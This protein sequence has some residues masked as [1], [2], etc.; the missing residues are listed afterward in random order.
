MNYCRFSLAWML[1]GTTLLAGFM[2]AH[3]QQPS[4]GR[5]RKIEF[6]DPRGSVVTSNLNQIA[7]EKTTF[8]NPEDD[9]K[10]SFDV[11]SPG[12]SL[13]GIGVPQMQRAPS[14][15]VNSKRLKELLE[16]RQEWLFLE[17][18]DYQAGWTAE[19]IFGIPE[20]GPNGEVKEKKSPLERY[21]ERLER[22][23]TA[24]TN[25]TRNEGL[26]G[27]GFG[28]GKKHDGSSK[29]SIGAENE[30]AAIPEIDNP[31]KQ[32]LRGNTGNP[33]FPEKT[34]PTGV[35]DVFGQDGQWKLESPEALRAQ[36]ARLDEF[37]RILDSRTLP[38]LSSS[39]PIS[40]IAPFDPLKTS[41][42]TTPA[43]GLPRTP[44]PVVTFA[45]VRDS[46]SPFPTTLGTV[47]RPFELPE[48]STSLP[49]M[50]PSPVLPEPARTPVAAPDFNIPKRRF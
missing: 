40:G 6:S 27:M 50:M 30:P 11:F 24:A 38:S 7:N 43:F 17:P 4:P 37:R 3:G 48:V 47:A 39:S 14:S 10:K 19:E 41:P 12:N 31:L 45:P 42:S 20:Y 22:A 13:Q 16:K 21:F 8:Q 18:E 46:S 36:A 26:F 29:D 44:D 34:K 49:G 28:P 5:A 35:S 15:G 32:L 25:R 33:L 1:A 23:N 2:A 9:L